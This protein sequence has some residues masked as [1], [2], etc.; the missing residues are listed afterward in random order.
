[1][2]SLR[3]FFEIDLVVVVLVH[4]RTNFVPDLLKSLHHFRH[5]IAPEHGFK[6][7]FC[8]LAVPIRIKHL[9]RDFKIIIAE[10]F[11]LVISRR[12]E[13]REVYL[14]VSVRIHALEHLMP[15]FGFKI[16]GTVMHFNTCLDFFN[17]QEAIF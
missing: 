6:L 9:E 15:I 7:F 10:E 13:L 8:Y 17:C 1:M 3:E 2:H 16:H 4:L 12:N 5:G 14:A 11:L